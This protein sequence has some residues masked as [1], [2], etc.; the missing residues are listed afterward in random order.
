MLHN[1]HSILSDIHVKMCIKSQF[2][3]QLIQFDILESEI[4]KKKI[5]KIEK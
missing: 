3:E 2:H 4:V 1:K 5:S